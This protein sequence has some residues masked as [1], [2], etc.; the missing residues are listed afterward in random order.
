MIPADLRQLM[1]QLAQPGSK[2]TLP[3]S[4][5]YDLKWDGVR[6][7]VYV[8]DGEVLIRSRNGIDITARYPDLVERARKAHPR[9]QIV[10]DGEIIVYNNVSERFDFGLA[11]KRDA[12]SMPYKITAMAA[13]YPATYAAFDLLYL[14][15]VDLRGEPLFRRVDQLQL[16]ARITPHLQV[17][18]HGNGF[19]QMW[20]TVETFHLEGL[21]AKDMTAPYR[22]GR[23]A[24]WQKFKNTKRVTAI[25]TGY[26]PG[27]GGRTNQ[28]GALYLAL[29]D[30]G[31]EVSVGKVG[32]G[33]KRSDH[34]PMLDVLRAGHQFLVEV[35]YLNVTDDG[36]LRHPSFKGVR[37]DVV[38]EDCTMEQVR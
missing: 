22:S 34:K 18:P 7:L 19:E 32:T 12:Q 27:E 36:Q 26:E 8:D 13:K 3:R 31:Q 30:G 24:A 10:L 38:R 25:V 14:D 2:A 5:L 21:I 37:A 1:P 4:V 23:G 6:G 17:S 20:Q 28:V 11:L 16:N 29:L 35:E 9:G 33:L 15:G